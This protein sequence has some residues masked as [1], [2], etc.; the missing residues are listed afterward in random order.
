MLILTL[1]NK[2]MGEI[3]RLQ[4]KQFEIAQSKGFYPNGEFVFG[5]QISLIHSEATEALEADRTDGSGYSKGEIIKTLNID[6]DNKFIRVF[7]KL[8]KNSIDDELADIVLRV[9]NLAEAANIDLENHMHAKMRYN[10]LR[11]HKHGNK[12]Y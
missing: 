7:E 10:S 11:P 8:H 4:K 9:F 1:K 3:A 5:V 6:K 2:I 12:K